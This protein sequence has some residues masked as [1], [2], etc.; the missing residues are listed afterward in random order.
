MNRDEAVFPEEFRARYNGLVDD[1][2]EFWASLLRPLPRSFRVNTLKATCAYIVG[3]FE[4]YGIEVRPVGWYAD[5]FTTDNETLG[6]TLERFLGMIYLQEL[7]SMLPPLV[8]AEELKTA[9]RVLDACAAPGS[10]ATQ[11]AALMGNRGLLVANDRDYRRIRGL[12]FNLN[13][14]GVLNAV[15]TQRDLLSLPLS[16]YDVILLD[17]PCSSEG[18]LRK[19][20]D[21]VMRWSEHRVRTYA[22]RQRQLIL[23]AFDMLAPGGILVYST[24]AFAPE[25]NEGVVHW[26]LDNRE[27][28]LLPISLPKLKTAPPVTE[29]RGLRYHPDVLKAVRIWSSLSEMSIPPWPVPSQP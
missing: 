5:A 22:G 27:A 9:R 26:L 11:L 21:L 17:A 12:K 14:A 6:S 10:K 7:V 8:V 13:K 4:S 29:W 20:P 19:N 15:I 16:P 28:R 24:C 1:P 23:R 2:R 3:R 18:T 25:E